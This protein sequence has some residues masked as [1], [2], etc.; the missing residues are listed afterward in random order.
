MKKFF[1]MLLSVFLMFCLVMPVQ[2]L[3]DTSEEPTRVIHLVY[4]DSGSMI[5]TDFTKVDTWCQAK[6][7]VEVF[8]AMLGEKDSMDVYYMS[9][10]NGDPVL[11]LKG[12]DGAAVNVAKVHDNV[13]DYGKNTPFSTVE[14]AYEDLTKVTAD[15]K[16][17]V[18]LTDGEFDG[19][20]RA[21]VEAYF[22]K[23]VDDI[24]VMYL[25]MGRKGQDISENVAKDIYFSKAKENSEI[26]NKITDICTRIFNSNRLEVDISAKKISFDIPMNELIV[27]AQ[28]AEVEINGIQK[29]DGTYLKST[30]PAVRVQYHEKAA[31]DYTGEPLVDRSLVGSIA[32]F[33][34]DFDA[35]DYTLDVTGAQ[36]IEVYYKPNIAIAAYLKDSEGNRVADISRI[37]DG[38]YVIEF[39]FVKAGT[40]EAVPESKLL[41][42]VTYE[43][44]V[45]NGGAAHDKTYNSGDRIYIE[46]GELSIDVAANYLEY[47]TVTTQLNY[48]VYGDK[49][50]TFSVV[51]NQD[52]TVTSDGM[53]TKKPIIVKALLDGREFT[54]EEWAE[55]GTPVGDIVSE[56]EFVMGE[57][58][59][60]KMDEIGIYHIYPTLENG[61][62]SDGVYD[63]CDYTF[64][65][66]GEHGDVNWYGTGKLVLQ[67]KDDRSWFEQNQEL[68]KR[69]IVC[70]LAFLFFLGYVP[71]VKKYLPRALKKRPDIKVTKKDGY[72]REVY[73]EPGA[74][75]KDLWT[76]I[77][78]Y[79]AETGM[80]VFVPYG[81]L[82][83]PAAARVKAG[84]GG[85]YLMNVKD[86]AG[87]K[88]IK[89]EGEAVDKDTTKP[90]LL[91]GGAYTN[92]TIGK[93]IYACDFTA[94]YM[95]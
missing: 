30:T 25:S 87:N 16:W 46:D 49:V 78:P 86:F 92:V 60:Q 2:V 67:L 4:D 54:A 23:K 36:T 39:G 35:G 5:S 3:A 72:K 93:T 40:T 94:E 38:E 24:K 61:K 10:Y 8:A 65:Y 51:E 80:I 7:A 56:I 62:P 37:K 69:I 73:N 68:F 26:L 11:S 48:A 74:F 20:V 21:D 84:G 91:S 45:Y 34:G 42:N 6:Y 58:K 43:A 66:V 47:H 44:L 81:A 41:G 50:I 31:A 76:T 13:I 88:N 19:F 77:L 14:R 52:Y 59:I 1:Y 57:L 27:F 90:I 79:K 53:E 85:M 95:A 9:K 33:K 71:G 83:A 89:F 75:K 15:E 17:L 64:N 12:N 28:G 70:S 82:D 32:T 29:A 22:D 55:M 63:D 18:V